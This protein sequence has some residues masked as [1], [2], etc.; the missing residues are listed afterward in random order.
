MNW[1]QFKFSEGEM[2]RPETF[3]PSAVFTETQ[4]GHARTKQPLECPGI[5]TRK[6]DDMIAYARAIKTPG[7][8]TA[9]T[10]SASFASASSPVFVFV[11]FRVASL[12]SED[13]C[14]E[15]IIRGL[16]EPGV[17][18]KLRGL[19]IDFVSHGIL[20]FRGPWDTKAIFFL[21]TTTFNAMPKRPAHRSRRARRPHVQLPCL[22]PQVYDFNSKISDEHTAKD[23]TADDCRDYDEK[24]WDLSA[25]NFLPAFD[26]QSDNYYQWSDSRQYQ[27]I[28]SLGVELNA[29]RIYPP[30]LC[31][32]AS[33]RD[34]GFE[35]CEM[36]VV[37]RHRDDLNNNHTVVGYL[38][39]LSHLCIFHLIHT[40]EKRVKSNNRATE[41]WLQH[42]EETGDID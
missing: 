22:I 14:V 20:S 3:S 25:K 15:G 24:A 34:R 7:A 26:V 2:I 1:G 39:P 4:I 38:T 32:H 23:P 35:T 31:H 19:P 5:R 36:S 41:E 9:T 27:D 8:C 29:G 12:L 10:N 30:P 21:L 40:L 33:N 11:C 18:K 16:K 6:Y 42:L 37:R 13:I 28:Q 17:S